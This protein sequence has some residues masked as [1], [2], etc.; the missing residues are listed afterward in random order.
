MPISVH[1]WKDTGFS[2]STQELLDLTCLVKVYYFCPHYKE[3][4]LKYLMDG[5][6]GS[7]WGCPLSQSK[8]GIWMTVWLNL[9]THITNYTSD[10]SLFID[11]NEH[12]INEA[13]YL[14]LHLYFFLG[15]IKLPSFFLQ[16]SSMSERSVAVVVIAGTVVLLGH[17]NRKSGKNI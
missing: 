12:K 15:N 17:E 10:P 13:R 2:S 7:Y 5:T 1:V 9:T 11:F 6:Q 8:C 3:K 16:R 14:L 4:T